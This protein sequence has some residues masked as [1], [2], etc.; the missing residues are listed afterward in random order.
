MGKHSIRI[1]K[2]VEENIA[3]VSEASFQLSAVGAA[4]GAAS[5]IIKPGTRRALREARR[6]ALSCDAV[7]DAAQKAQVQVVQ[8]A[9]PVRTVQTAQPVQNIAPI[10][11]LSH[12]PTLLSVVAAPTDSA[13]AGEGVAT[14]AEYMNE[15]LVASKCDHVDVQAPRRFSGLFKRTRV[16]TVSLAAAMCGMSGIAM[17]AT[18]ASQPGA[19][20]L[21]SA[22]A[23]STSPTN[24]LNVQ[25]DVPFTV[26]IDGKKRSLT[27]SEGASVGEA[28]SDAGIYLGEKDEL[29]VSLS[30]TVTPHMNIEIFTVSTK[31]V[32]ETFTEAHGT[33]EEKTS[34]LKE[35]ERK[36][37]TAGK[38][39][40]G[41]R[42][43]TVYYRNGQ[44]ISREVI[45]Q[46]VT[47]QPVDE[48]V[49]VGTASSTAPT[50]SVGGAP[51]TGTKTD[52]LAAA[53]IPQSDWSYVD[54]LVQRESG[55][56]PNA[57]N[58]SSG[59]CGLAQALPCSKMGPNW[60][61]PVTALKWQYN[62][63]NGRY[64]GYAGAVAH[65]Q[66]TGWY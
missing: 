6:H 61:D 50:P 13:P 40:S 53:G 54:W 30:D 11:P 52:W 29:S 55:W 42:T 49:Q 35:G 57:V 47:T 48:V 23:A 56:N 46:T 66:S 22:N 1:E 15:N 63:V 21:N 17:A 39:G 27:A 26:Q 65:S 9:Q 34:E 44:E 28:L 20:D 5:P 12:T 45:A 64:G 36:V 7:Q 2:R 31:T 8:T 4:H 18:N 24:V 51:V 33:K 14:Y 62:Y 16:M 38:D 41:T 58:A 59:A 3:E 37:V 19:A 25:R 10:A 43:V 60:N 32:V